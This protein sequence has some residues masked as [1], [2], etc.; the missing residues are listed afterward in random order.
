MSERFYERFPDYDVLD[1]WDSPSWNDQTRAVVNRRLH[2]VPDRR[3]LSEAEWQILEAVCERLIPQP[4]RRD[5]PV[6][7]VPF[8]DEKLFKNQGDGY[9]FEAMPPM[10]D[11]WRRG[12]AAI[13]DEARARWGGGFRELPANQQDAVLR[14][15]QHNDTR[16]AAWQGLSA[17]RFFSNLL[18]REVVSVYYA[19]PAAWSE[20]GFGGP[21]SPRGY[22]RLGFDRRD[23]WEA[24]ERYA[25]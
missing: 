11:A 7:I 13:D 16:S 19:H 20:I 5:R 9:R 18:L 21:A 2:Q 8:I 14:A 10:R 17:K 12:I 15:I 24:E 6:P 25:R 1:K 22:V 4:D 23:S 3:F